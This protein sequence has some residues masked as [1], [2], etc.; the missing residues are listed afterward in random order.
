MHNCFVCGNERSDFGTANKNFDHHRDNEHSPWKYIFYVYY[1]REKGEDDLSGLEY[2]T[3]TCFTD[4][5]TSWLP[6]GKT[7]YLGTLPPNQR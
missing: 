5:N 7:L 6:I 4:L 3:W 2:F 1:M